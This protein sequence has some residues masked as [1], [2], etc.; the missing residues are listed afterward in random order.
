L[1]H[2]E[3]AP[4][5]KVKSERVVDPTTQ[6]LINRLSLALDARVSIRSDKRK[7]EIRL[8]FN[9]FDQLE[10]VCNKLLQL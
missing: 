2:P 1:N 8:S 10:Y 6:D 5:L 7:Q 3:K 4:L 9:E